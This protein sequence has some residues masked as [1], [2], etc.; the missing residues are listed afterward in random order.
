MA[1]LFASP[2]ILLLLA[3]NSFVTVA[4][5]ACVFGVVIGLVFRDGLVAAGG[6]LF[7]AAML[8]LRG[9]CGSSDGFED[10][11]ARLSA[12]FDSFVAA[13]PLA[14]VLG[15]AAIW[16]IAVPAG[17][18]LRRGDACRGRSIILGC[19]VPLVGA[20]MLREIMA[21]LVVGRA[22]PVGWSVWQDVVAQFSLPAG[23]V[24]AVGCGAAAVAA[25]KWFSVACWTAASTGGV[26]LMAGGRAD[27]GGLSVGTWLALVQ[28]VALA[29]WLWAGE[30]GGRMAGWRGIAA[31]ACAG[32]LAGVWPLPGGVW[33]WRLVEE[34]LRG[35]FGLAWD[36]ALFGATIVAWVLAVVAWLPW[37]WRVLRERA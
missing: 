5:V 17:E 1:L 13:A 19:L 15:C 4:V 20:V 37:A 26:V 31:I 8:W 21:D 11:G 6:V 3:T 18:A 25:R 35:G 2:C 9:A 7:G 36:R 23:A 29:I 32:S 10:A 33:R 12:T 34:M 16:M 30:G 27:A 28:W 22:A 24:A 14:A